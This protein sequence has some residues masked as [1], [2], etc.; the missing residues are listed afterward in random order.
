MGSA[1]P[2]ETLLREKG[3][4]RGRKAQRFV[5]ADTPRSQLRSTQ[6]QGPQEPPATPQTRSRELSWP[7]SDQSQT[8]TLRMWGSRGGKPLPSRA[9]PTD[10]VCISRTAPT[11]S[12]RS[13]STGIRTFLETSFCLVCRPPSTSP[14]PCISTAAS[15]AQQAGAS[16]QSDLHRTQA[17][18]P[19]R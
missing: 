19:L 6:P 9:T 3:R 5:E 15:R 12:S 14:F 2:Q 7:C 11:A 16:V 1:P 18:T 8:A 10:G 13:D 17:P 4:K